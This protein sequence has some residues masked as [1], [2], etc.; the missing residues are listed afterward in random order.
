MG[1]RRLLHGLRALLW[2]EA[3]D[4]E[5]EEEVTHYMEME[6][7]ER[8][9]AGAREEE[10]RRAVRLA[11]GDAGTVREQVRT[12]GWENAVEA[13]L[14]DLRL[15]VRRLARSPGFTSVAVLTLGLG[16]GASTAIFSAVSAVL[17]DPL[18]YPDADRLVA[19]DD[20][21]GDGSPLPVT[22]GTYVELAQRSRAL[23]SLSVVRTW[24]PFLTGTGEPE[25]VDGQRVSAGYF[26]VLG[27]RPAMG[28]GLDPA[29]DRVGGPDV[30]VLSD[31]LWRRR[32]GADSAIV[33]GS[34]SLDDRPYTVVGVMPAGFQNVPGRPA[35]VWTLL[36]YDRALPSF[37]GREWGHHLEIVARLAPGAS[38][39][40]AREELS[41]IAASPLP[42][43][44][45]PAWASLSL[46]L[47]VR[48]LV[49]AATE[50]ARPA[51]LPLLGAVVLLLGIA[52]VNVTNLLLARGAQRGGEIAM[53][54][55]LGAGRVRLVR[56]V[57][58]ESLV[59]AGLGGA[60]GVLVAWLGVDAL[61]ALSP[62]GLPR[63]DAI[64]LDGGA[65]TFALAVTTL[66]GVAAGL[67]PALGLSRG[68]LRPDVRGASLRAGR[69]HHAAR[70]A[71][72]VTEVALAL[73]L[74][75]GAGL[76]LRSVQRVFAV[77]PGFEPSGAV[78]LQVQSV[79][80]RF[81][82]DEQVHR[83]FSE[84]IE[85]VARVGGVRSA[86]LTTQLPLSGDL[87]VYGINVVDAPSPDV[88][89]GAGYRYGVSP[90]YLEAMGIPLL[91][92]RGLDDGD[93]AGAPKAVVISASLAAGAFGEADPIGRRL[94][95]GDTGQEPYTVVGVAGDV[96]QEAL[97][98][99]T[100]N[101]VYLSPEQWSFADRTRW[102][103]ARTEG[104][105]AAIVPAIREAIRSVDPGQPVVRVATLEAMIGASE[106]RRRFALA[107][108]EAF[109]ALAL[110]LA[111]VGL[112]GV[113]AGS[114][115]ERT[116][117]IGVRAALGASREGL[118]VMVVRQAMGLTGLG[119]ALGL[120]GAGAGSSV[121]A[122]LLFG[123]SRLD[124]VTY[125]SVI[126]VLVGVAA[127]AAWV[128]AARASRV[129]PVLA[130][131]S[132]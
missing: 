50:G 72:V 27:V 98:V 79:G 30:V 118:R 71:L 89:S 110:V 108:L 121:L 41:G 126:G 55:A 96:K 127:L 129:D 69:R 75:V 10:A 24:Q 93:V 81:T 70:R 102:V 33:G 62:P 36:R 56:Q 19:V 53:R 11:Y 3:T 57:V 92:G 37:D 77:P 122:S 124:P 18:D 5:L 22:F 43:L 64:A 85:A 47:H 46:G 44:A 100:A 83:F 114:V 7:A 13:L 12:F 117:E 120:L 132:D 104:D 123:I 39:G 9:A 25:R 26:D 23:A 78:A 60:L 109:A 125:G 86:G 80:Q 113:L 31:A 61:V 59:L 130:L 15:S 115:S 103:V 95:V 4:R 105:P 91:R 40:T 88:Q 42:T 34:V 2:R 73:I 67:V 28:P 97:D 65:L 99:V 63:A 52:C 66:V 54:T 20:R 48:P 106:A 49:Q 74:L 128:P 131:R 90:G 29:D 14:S 51:L 84:A 116:R 107:I 21:A 68:D 58:T 112:Y 45:R 101:A 8:V 119:V 94:H 111:G 6:L 38:V 16:I 1:L 76:L 32:F 82:D 35:D 17:L 87:D